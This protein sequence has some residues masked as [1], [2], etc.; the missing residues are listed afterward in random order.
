[1]WG[2]SLQFWQ[3]VVKVALAVAAG[4]G[5]LSVV[6]GF[7]AGILGYRV[8]E[9]ARADA[10]RRIAEAQTSVGEARA[11]AGKAH[12]AAAKWQART[13]S[14]EEDVTASRR[15]AERLQAQMA[16]RF[17]T[18][19]QEE[20]L[21]S[22]LRERGD[23]TVEISVRV[24]GSDPETAQYASDLAAVL[25]AAGLSVHRSMA[26]IPDPPPGLLLGAPIDSV[27]FELIKR[28]FDEAGISLEFAGIGSALT[29]YVGPKP[30]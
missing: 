6:A 5:A 2:Y 19:A 9:A 29:L 11:E 20:K 23:R 28:A 25:A 8:A 3:T 18:H 10:D 13:K 1:M 30:M 24:Q 15:E 7:L 4:A 14:L 21:L 27:D 17:I 16:S 22:V 12:E 26:L